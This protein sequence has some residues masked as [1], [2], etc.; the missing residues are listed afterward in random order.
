MV[1]RNGLTGEDTPLDYLSSHRLFGVL[2]RVVLVGLSQELVPHE[3][4]RGHY[5]YHAGD[6]PSFLFV[7]R[8]G[9]VALSRNDAQGRTRVLLTHRTDDVVGLSS[10]VFGLRR[11][12]TACALVNTTGLLLERDTFMYLCRH[13][14]E[15]S[16]QVLRELYQRVLYSWED[17]PRL[18]QGPVTS[19]VAWYLLES[20]ARAWPSR[21]NPDAFDLELPHCDIALL[22]RTRRE[23]VTRALAELKSQ[24]VIATEDRSVLILK[25]DLLRKVAQHQW[26]VEPDV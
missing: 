2:P 19:R 16:N 17:G 22:L 15:L 25:P 8:S 3:C 20:A 7:V 26:P 14:P 13:L 24:G 4:C 23:A 11:T 5:I 21:P 6:A 9:L 1:A 10:V 12:L 18:T